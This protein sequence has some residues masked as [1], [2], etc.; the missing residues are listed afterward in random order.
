[1]FVDDKAVIVPTV[2]TGTIP[3]SGSARLE[4]ISTKNLVLS[5]DGFSNMPIAYPSLVNFYT[6]S[7]DCENTGTLGNANDW[8]TQAVAGGTLTAVTTDIASGIP[9]NTEAIDLVNHPGVVSINSGGTTNSGGQISWGNP[10]NGI[11]IKGGERFDCIFN[12]VSIVNT[13]SR[14]GFH[15]ANTAVDVVDGVY[16]DTALNTGVVTARTRSNSFPATA[17]NLM[18][19]T[20]NTWYYFRIQINNNATSATFL[21]YDMQGA[22]LAQTTITDNFPL[23]A[24]RDVLPKAQAFSSTGGVRLLYQFDYIGWAVPLQRGATI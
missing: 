3:A 12:A 19:L 8:M 18:T 14:I 2:A 7:W 5:R 20:E 15:D 22:V 9:T 23:A 24:G 21:I 11:L 6:S 4:G 16:F 17:I 1:M 10:L 13:V